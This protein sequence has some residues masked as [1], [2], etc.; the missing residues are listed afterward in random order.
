MVI[1][2]RLRE[3]INR[4]VSTEKLRDLAL[5]TGMRPLRTAGM[6]KVFNGITSIEE[7]DSGNSA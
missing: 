1:N 3:L 4:G 7:V 5:Q 2:D 6:E